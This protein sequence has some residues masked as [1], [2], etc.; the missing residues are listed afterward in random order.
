VLNHVKPR[1]FRHWGTTPGLN[2]IYAHLNRVIKSRE[3]N[4]M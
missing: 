3:L 1:L 4:A 2:L